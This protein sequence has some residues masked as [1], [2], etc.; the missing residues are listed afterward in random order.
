MT[1][2]E[3]QACGD[4]LPMLRFL[5]DRASER[6]L[7]LLAVAACREIWD[8]I[9]DGRS[10][11]AVVVA[12][13]FAD[14][15]AGDADLLRACQS[16]HDASTA[17]HA[18]SPSVGVAA[19][20]AARASHPEIRRHI[21]SDGGPVAMSLHRAK[22][23]RRAQFCRI[24]R[25]IFGPLPFRPIMIE[26]TCSTPTITNLAQTIYNDRE[27]WNNPASR[28]SF[29]QLPILADALEEVGCT[30]ADLLAHCRGDGPHARGCWVIDLLLGKE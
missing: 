16:A 3:W 26:P 1:E 23:N 8:R 15:L 4:P 17:A 21:A 30:D 20:A 19:S 5:R 9:T 11:E 12:E 13:M 29:D 2:A 22:A 14:G 6:K 27:V 7:R 25:C 10:R 18:Q 28:S 24:V